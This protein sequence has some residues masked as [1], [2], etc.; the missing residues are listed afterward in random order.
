MLYFNLSITLLKRFPEYK[1][2][3]DDNNNSNNNNMN[4]CNCLQD[5]KTR[6]CYLIFFVLLL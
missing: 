3:D 4:L 6:K 2:H 5:D 1:M